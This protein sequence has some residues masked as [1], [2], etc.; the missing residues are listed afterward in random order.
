MQIKVEAC[1][2]GHSHYY[3]LTMPGGGREIVHGY[4]WTR[5][6]ATYALDLLERVYGFTRRNVRFIH[7]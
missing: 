4:V 5:G 2:N 7:H 1:W 3:R 6:V